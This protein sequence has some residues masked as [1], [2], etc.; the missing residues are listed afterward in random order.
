MK[1]PISFSRFGLTAGAL[2]FLALLFVSFAFKPSRP[3]PRPA[4]PVIAISKD[5][6]YYQIPDGVGYSGQHMTNKAGLLT[7]TTEMGQNY[8]LQSDSATITGFLYAEVKA[9]PYNP[10]GKPRLPLNISLVIDRS[11]SMEGAKL[12]N[13]K[14]A[15]N[16]LVDKLNDK[17]MLSI[18]VYETNVGV[19]Q[20][21]VA[22]ADKK[23]LHAIIDNIE[24]GGST[25]LN[26][27]MSE[28]YN[29][30]KAS[31]RSGYVNRV[32]LLSDGI[33]NVGVTDLST[34]QSTAKKWFNNESI[35]IS[36]FGVGSDYNENLMTS[37]A[38]NGGGNYYYI[39][40]PDQIPGMLEKEI[41]GL[42]SVVAQQAQLT[43]TL[44]AGISILRVY[45]GNYE[46]DKGN[47]MTVNLKDIFANET[48]AVL[49]KFKIKKG[50]NSDLVFATR[51]NF[52]DATD[53]NTAKA[54][55]NINVMKPVTDKAVYLKNFSERVMQQCTIFESN[56]Q[57]ERAMKAADDGDYEKARA[58]GRN[59]QGYTQNN[60]AK[61]K[62]TTELARQDSIVTIY[63]A[64]LKDVE[65]KS[66]EY[67]NDMQKASKMMNYEIR[68]KKVQEVK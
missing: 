45:G 63:N 13:V 10:S 56:D 32:L 27:G 49:V 44:P 33:A 35:S 14:K 47:I 20:K 16:I 67:K 1:Q 2:M 17:D 43:F 36:T 19:M 24:I 50:T 25:N 52:T 26:G 15:A 8:Y 53:N 29:Q 62:K 34:L 68:T 61:C 30:V 57:L 60:L 64:K 46:M 54:I 3:A 6:D 7:L 31:Y 9:A 23:A 22:V 65:T 39:K 51:L 40:E 21:S 48:K 38:E 41:N 66:Y 55:D 4:A 12:A 18:V 11:G 5:D 28:G 58:V 42:L 37:L 59:T